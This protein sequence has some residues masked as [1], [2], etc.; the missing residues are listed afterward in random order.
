VVQVSRPGKGGENR[1]EKEDGTLREDIADCSRHDGDGDVA[2][3]IE[4][5]VPPDAPS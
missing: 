2:G 3:M 4:G 1:N 5:R